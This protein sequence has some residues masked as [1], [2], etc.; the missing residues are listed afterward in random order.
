MIRIRVIQDTSSVLSRERME[1]IQRIFRQSFSELADYADK[2]PSLIRNPFRYG[3]CSALIVAEGALGRV[4]GFALINYFPEI[5]CCFLDFIATRPGIRGSGIG[6]TLYEAATDFSLTLGAKGLYLETQ[7]DVPDLTPDS[8]LLERAR[9]Q[10]RFYEQRGA[11][12]IMN[13]AYSRPVGNPPTTALLLFDGLGRTSS[14]RRSEAQEALKEILTKRF[15]QTS[16]PEYIQMVIDSFEDDPV[17][18][19]PARQIKTKLGQTALLPRRLPRTYASV[20][21]PK[22]EI[23]HVKERGYFERPVRVETIRTVLEST[24]LFVSVVPRDYGE[25]WILAVHESDF[26]HYLRT[27]CTALQQNRPIY[28]D[29]FPIRRS[30][31][32][33]K[34]LPVQAGYYCIDTGTPLYPN[35]YKIAR[36]AVNT[37]LTAADEILAGKRLAYAICRPP[38]HHAGKRFYGGFCYF[39]NAAIAAHYLSSEAKVAILDIDFHHGNGTQDIFYNRHDV[40]TVSIH[41]HPDYSYPY[42]SGYTNETG[43][44]E[45]LNFNRNFPLPPRTDEVKYLRILDRAIDFIGKFDPEILVISLGFDI[46]KGDPTGTFLMTPSVF[47]IIGG[48]LTAMRRPLLVVQEGG[49]NIRSIR[50]GTEAFFR[51]C[52]EQDDSNGGQ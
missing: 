15:V 29:T 9:L 39:N 25:K 47:K 30:V 40:L 5:K 17:Q 7:P 45:G 28:P 18:F 19:R 43:E 49:Y 22:H 2:I 44:G 27:V 21:V 48:R 4:D 41:G 11:R 6:G 24:G 35:A 20:Y 10:I 36:A 51:G 16:S 50:H 32:R 31:N 14:L 8:S 34:E 12:V 23:H 42:F 1:Q 46:L 38:G 52:R 37:V 33:P 3:Y 13:R 26:V